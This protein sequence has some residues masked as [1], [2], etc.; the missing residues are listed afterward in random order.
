MDDDMKLQEA[1]E[2]VAALK[3]F[4]IHALVY[5]CVMSLLIAIDM[6]TGPK[7]WAQWPLLGWGLGLMGH[8]IAVYSPFRPFS[9][10]WEERKIKEHLA[11]M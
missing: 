4:Y 8:A 10:D 7:W 5:V 3:G 6:L 1:T 9:R 11:R 2:H